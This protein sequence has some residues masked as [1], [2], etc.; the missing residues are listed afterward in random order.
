VIALGAEQQWLPLRWEFAKSVEAAFKLRRRERIDVDLLQV[1]LLFAI[2]IPIPSASR[3]VRSDF[4]GLR[5][6]SQQNVVSPRP[7]HELTKLLK[8][9]KVKNS[10]RG[11]FLVV[12][13]GNHVP[14][15]PGD[16]VC[17]R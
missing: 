13:A 12:V 9:E 7:T 6:R 1:I 16:C 15:E 3:V 8:D 5:W 17:Q 10:S 11:D 14:V 4:I 2:V